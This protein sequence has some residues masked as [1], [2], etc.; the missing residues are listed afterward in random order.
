LN[1]PQRTQIGTLIY[2]EVLSSC[3]DSQFEQSKPNSWCTSITARFRIKLQIMVQSGK[4][5]NNSKCSLGRIPKHLYV[6]VHHLHMQK[7]IHLSQNQEILEVCK[8]S[9]E[10]GKWIYRYD[11][12]AG[13]T[14]QLLQQTTSHADSKTSLW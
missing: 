13:D 6:Q 7:Q 4:S 1:W 3:T 8:S 10:K 5:S 9:R 12:L 14:I 2:F 11:L